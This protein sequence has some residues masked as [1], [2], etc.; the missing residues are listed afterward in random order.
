MPKR[1]AA[2]SKSMDTVPTIGTVAAARGREAAEK[3]GFS[4]V[5]PPEGRP[6]AG[7]SGSG[8]RLWATG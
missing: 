5:S 1:I 8:F 6:G 4:G 7:F 2:V 3:G